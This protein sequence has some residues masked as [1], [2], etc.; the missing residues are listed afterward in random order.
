MLSLPLI[1]EDYAAME[2]GAE[3]GSIVNEH[4]I[5]TGYFQF[6]EWLPGQHVRLEKNEDYWN[7]EAKLDSV[8]FKVVSEDLTRIAELETGDSH[9]SNPLSPNDLERVENAEGLYAS[10]TD[11]VSLDYVGFN[12]NQ[13]P[14]DDIRV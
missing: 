9:I 7:G 8:T 4:P 6:D 13:E 1:E 14:F 10:R 2:T 5:G 11:S 3:T 12:V